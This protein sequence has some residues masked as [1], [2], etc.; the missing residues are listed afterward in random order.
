V[1]EKGKKA[2]ACV[3]IVFSRLF[4][5]GYWRNGRKQENHRRR[6]GN[7]IAFIGSKIK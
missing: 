3:E 2:D 7:D 6:H 1:D 5:S 4:P